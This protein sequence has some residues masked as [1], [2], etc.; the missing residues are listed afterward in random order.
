MVGKPEELSRYSGGV[1]GSDWWPSLPRSSCMAASSCSSRRC[2]RSSFCIS[3]SKRRLCS[4]NRSYSNLFFSSC[5]QSSIPG[6]NEITGGPRRVSART[7]LSYPVGGHAHTNCTLCNACD[8]RKSAWLCLTTNNTTNVKARGQ[9]HKPQQASPTKPSN[10]R[11]Y[12]RSGLNA[13]CFQA[14]P[15]GRARAAAL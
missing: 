6:F 12:S 2:A 3:A 1:V 7:P 10:I 14:S 8:H 13:P 15:A 11:S 9:S 5:A 4:L